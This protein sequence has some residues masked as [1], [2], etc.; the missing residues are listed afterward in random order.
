MDC[1]DVAQV[2]DHCRALVNT[3]MNLL[4]PKNVRKFLSICSIGGFLRR[5]EL[6]GV[7]HIRR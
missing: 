4:Y 6:H 7:N 1:I 5:A 2:G 3:V